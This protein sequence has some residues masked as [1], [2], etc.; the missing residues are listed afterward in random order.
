MQGKQMLAPLLALLAGAIAMHDIESSAYI[1]Q[2][3]AVTTR[4]IAGPSRSWQKGLNR[5]TIWS[6]ENMYTEEAC[7][8]GLR[9]RKAD[10]AYLAEALQIPEV[11]VTDKRDVFG[12]MEALVVLLHRMSQGSTWEGLLRFLGGRGRSSYSQVFYYMLDHLYDTFSDRITDVN[13]W[14]GYAQD[15]ADAIYAACGKAPR[16][17][18]FI[19]GT[20]RSNCRPSGPN[21][22][23]KAVYSGYKKTHGLKFQGVIGPNGMILDLFGAVSGRRGD[24]YMLHASN[25]LERMEQMCNNL[26]EEYYVYGDPAYP[27]CQ[28]IL[29][30]FK[31]LMTPAEQEL[32]TAMSGVRQTVEWAYHLVTAL[33]SYVD[34]NKRLKIRQQPVGRIYFIAAFLT[35]V[36]CC[37][38]GNQILNYFSEVYP[39]S[40]LKVDLDSYLACGLVP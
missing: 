3:I 16:C 29:R 11:I 30:G 34:C 33:W 27:L 32:S 7:W 2:A 21:E 1:F 24:G 12:R 5:V 8:E 23:Q 35:N 31:G 40:S 20:L 9:V 36:H 13:R 6:F 39:Q 28:Y 25:F 22:L 17:I 4:L 37:L 14:A 19:D 38:Y 18:G 15:F 26:N 10:M